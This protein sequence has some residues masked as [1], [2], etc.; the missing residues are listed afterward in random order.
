M[1]VTIGSVLKDFFFLKMDDNDL[2]NCFYNSFFKL[3]FLKRSKIY[4]TDNRLP[5]EYIMI[6]IVHFVTTVPFVIGQT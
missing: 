5:Y 6:Y 2:K 3:I 4:F 1:A